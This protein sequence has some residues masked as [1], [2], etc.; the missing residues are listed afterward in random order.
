MVKTVKEIHNILTDQMDAVLNST[1]LSLAQKTKLLATLSNS[2]KSQ[3]HVYL[4][5]AQQSSLMTARNQTTLT[6]PH[7]ILKMPTLK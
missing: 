2:A 6:P 4:R 5:G 3:S 7:T 1:E